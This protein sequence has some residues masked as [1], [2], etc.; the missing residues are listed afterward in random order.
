MN[1]DKTLVAVYGS[2][3][4]GFGNHRLL[5]ESELA[6]KGM[7][8]PEFRMLDLG[9]YPGIVEGEFQVDVEVYEV[10]EET[11]SR[12][13]RLEGYPSFYDRKK[14]EVT[15]YDDLD[16]K[17]EAWIYFLKS[18]DIHRARLSEVSDKNDFGITSWL[19]K[20]HR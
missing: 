18:N 15:D 11:F 7:T 19:K 1:K 16:K 17:Q 2:L 12:L 8:T 6:F 20:G 4:A 9:S 5:S 3:K 13:D 14:V 10:D